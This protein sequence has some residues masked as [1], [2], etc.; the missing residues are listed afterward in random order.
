MNVDR[1]IRKA[2][3]RLRAQTRKDVGE[4]VAR[5]AGTDPGR[6]KAVWS[7]IDR[8]GN[9]VRRFAYPDRA[10]AAAFAA[11]RDGCVLVVEK[12]KM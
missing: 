1:E 10:A 6:R 8:K 2:E 12:V 9:C 4:R 3:L 11:E 7:V 5:L